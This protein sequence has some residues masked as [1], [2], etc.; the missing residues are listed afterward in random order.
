VIRNREALDDDRK[1]ILPEDVTALSVHAPNNRASKY[2]RQKPI[3]FLET[4]NGK[5]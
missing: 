1:T 2:I 3:T 4:S 5:V